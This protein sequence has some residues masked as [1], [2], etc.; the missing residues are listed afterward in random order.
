[1][2]RCGK[3]AFFRDFA[4]MFQ[5]SAIPVSG[6]S[7]EKIKQVA[8]HEAGS[9]NPLIHRF[10]AILKGVKIQTT[11]GRS[12]QRKTLNLRKYQRRKVD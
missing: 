6:V 10:T 5:G 9:V 3:F 1:M 2:P 12:L 7:S 11:R 8:L 4:E